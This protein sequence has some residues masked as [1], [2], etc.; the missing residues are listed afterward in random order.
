MRK[1][2]KIVAIAALLIVV[3]SSFLF[4][5]GTQLQLSNN[6]ETS[7]SPSPAITPTSAP[8]PN[9]KIINFIYLGNWHGTTLGGMLDL[10]SLN[11]TNLGTIDVENL[12]VILNT[13]KTKEKYDITPTPIPQYNPYHFLDEDINGK[14]YPLESLK[15]NETRTIEKSYL[16][17]GF[18]LVEPFTLTAT[19]K[20]NDTILEEA[21]IMI[22]LTYL[23]NK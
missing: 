18:L 11:Y 8:T 5:Q 13:N 12:T 16:D 23:S 20:S 10:F 7:P 2:I 1:G 4:W 21:T 3:I 15:A 17:V 14:I 19:L 9:V 6:N 22:P